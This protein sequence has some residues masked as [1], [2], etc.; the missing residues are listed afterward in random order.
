VLENESIQPTDLWN[1]DETGFRIVVGKDQF[2]IT[3]R[4][5]QHYLGVPENRE[6]AIDIEAISVGR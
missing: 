2:I 3:K 1:M 5:Q 4:R 6:S